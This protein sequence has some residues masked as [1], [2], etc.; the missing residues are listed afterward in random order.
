[1]RL[2]SEMLTLKDDKT[3]EK[4]NRNVKTFATN[5]YHGWITKSLKSELGNH[6]DTTESNGKHNDSEEH[7]S[8]EGDPNALMKH[9]VTLIQREE[10]RLTSFLE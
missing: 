1:M 6:V 10:K 4:K 9:T 2:V 3:F 5:L 7:K 8:V